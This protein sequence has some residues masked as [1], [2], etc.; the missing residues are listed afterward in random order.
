MSE[1]EGLEAP[2]EQIPAVEAAPVQEATAA[3]DVEELQ[4]ETTEEAKTF[5]Q[6]ELDEIVRRRLEKAERKWKREQVK[7]AEPALPEYDTE[8]EAPDPRQ[9]IEQYEASK[10]QAA[11]DEQYDEREEAALEKYDDF[12]QVAYNPALPI[13]PTMALVIKASEIGP[14]IL[15]HLGSNVKDAARISKLPDM[16]QA[17]E[18]GRIEAKMVADPPARKTSTAPAPIAP[19]TA[20]NKAAPVYDTTDPR[21]A[22]TMS[23]SDWI[24]AD[25]LRLMRKLEAQRNLR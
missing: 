7:P 11:I 25:E 5:T 22:K 14:D 12:Q 20:H 23:T 8:G 24:K 3:P 4:P 9:I 13:T 10:Q 17:K 15:Y 18:I 1:V 2:V 19:V 16:L 6:E 21:A